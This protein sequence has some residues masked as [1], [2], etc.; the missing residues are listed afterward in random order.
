[1]AAI[2]ALYRSFCA[3]FF[4]KRVTLHAFGEAISGDRMMFWIVFLS[5]LTA[6]IAMVWRLKIS[7]NLSAQWPLGLAGAAEVATLWGYPRLRAS[8]AVVKRDDGWTA[9]YRVGGGKMREVKQKELL[10][11]FKVGKRDVKEVKSVWPRASLHNVHLRRMEIESWIGIEDAAACA[12]LCGILASALE[13][14]LPHRSENARYAVRPAFNANAFRLD[15]AGIVQ[16]HAAKIIR[17]AVHLRLVQRRA[18]KKKERD[19]L[20]I[21]ASD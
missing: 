6:L 17:D 14:W 20:V 2:T 16:V 4:K 13:D 15:L 21:P 7:V 10:A 3:A 9:Y 5:V 19:T 1:M 8:F 18:N 12:L 11:L